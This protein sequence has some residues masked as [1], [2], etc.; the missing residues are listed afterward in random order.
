MKQIVERL[1]AV[2]GVPVEEVLEDKLPQAPAQ[3]ALYD[4]AKSL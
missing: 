2:D 4:S 1:L 3:A